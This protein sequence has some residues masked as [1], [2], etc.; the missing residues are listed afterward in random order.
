MFTDGGQPDLFSR[1]AYGGGKGGGGGGGQQYVPPQP[2]V[3]TDPVNGMT[4]TDDPGAGGTGQPISYGGGY[5]GMVPDTG[6]KTGSQKLNE[7]I[8]QRQA[9]EKTTSDTAAAT[10]TQ[11]AADKETAFQGSRQTAYDDAVTAI[12]NQFRQQG[13]DPGKYWESDILPAV[14][15]QFHSVQDLDPNPS[16]AFPTNLG[17][18]ILN[19]LTSG[20]RTQATNQLNQTFSPT[21]SQTALPDSLT[22]QYVGGL[23]NEQFDPLMAGLTNAQKRGTLT[24][25]GYQ[26]ALDAL[27]QKKAA[28]TST[29]QNLGQGILA[30]D[31]KSLDDYI[32]G[33][34]SDV[35]NLTLGS[36]FD[37]STY[38]S[39]AA[40]KAAG[41]TSDFGGALRN[42]VGQTKFADLSE[43][44]NAGGAVQ[45][46]QNPNAANPLGGTA[47]T[48][49]AYV[50]PDTLDAQKRGL[51][52]TG[53]F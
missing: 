3:Y 36:T 49:P 45:G 24:G 11:A 1:A 46:A 43:L 42:A 41:F 31:R 33:A 27:N 7:E 37:P 28:A 9:G 30:T 25:A 48:S 5:Y 17:D 38:G 44:I 50:A 12:G 26:G 32:S 13:L 2:H 23:V 29:V 4:F 51:G 19:N 8:A 40:S 10:A 39:T 6:G 35:N 47:G 53:A 14:Q 15:R 18:T 34:R 16:A 20:Q 21:Y 22:G 52:N